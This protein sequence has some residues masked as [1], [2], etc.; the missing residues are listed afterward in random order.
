MIKSHNENLKNTLKSRLITFH[1]GPLH[2]LCGFLG[3]HVFGF[4]GFWVFGFFLDAKKVFLPCKNASFRLQFAPVLLF[5]VCYYSTQF[6]TNCSVTIADFVIITSTNCQFYDCMITCTFM[7]IQ[8]ISIFIMS[9]SFTLATL[10][11]CF[12]YHFHV[13]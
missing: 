10:C 11:Y 5:V 7:A 12:G 2:T 3:F 13:Y 6:C 1:L 9:I 4:L 8:H